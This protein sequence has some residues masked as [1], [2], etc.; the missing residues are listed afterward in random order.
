MG[1]LIFKKLF[2]KPTKRVSEPSIDGF[3]TILPSQL[4][5]A[6][7]VSRH[8][9]SEE[10]PRSQPALPFTSAS[11]KVRGERGQPRQ[12]RCVNIRPTSEKGP[13]AFGARSRSPRPRL[14]DIT[15]LSPPNPP[16]SLGKP[17]AGLSLAPEQ[18]AAPITGGPLHC[19]CRGLL[20][21]DGDQRF[22]AVTPPTACQ[23]PTHHTMCVLMQA[24]P[25]APAAQAA[26]TR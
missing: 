7:W 26:L 11:D 20:L 5:V 3:S 15:C 21:T 24:F 19:G 2:L 10:P 4:L 1:Y 17:S 25:A 6:R 22:L 8:H 23:S 14:A 13:G 9:A 18:P 12:P 16:H